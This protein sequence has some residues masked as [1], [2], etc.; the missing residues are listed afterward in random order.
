MASQGYVHALGGLGRRREARDDWMASLLVS[1]RCGSASPA[2]RLTQPLGPL[3][4]ASG[5]GL[6][7]R[8][9]AG[10]RRYRVLPIQYTRTAGL[11]NQGSLLI[12]VDQ[13]QLD[14]PRPSTQRGAGWVRS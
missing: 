9:R 12:S 6:L 8:T 3:C 14:C 7:H 5:F 10:L 2:L 13:A 4:W 1:Q 11:R